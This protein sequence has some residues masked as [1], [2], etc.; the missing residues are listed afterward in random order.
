[1]QR[2]FLVHAKQDF[3]GV[4]VDDIT[5]GEEVEGVFMDDEDGNNSSKVSVK[6]REAVPLGHK[7]ALLDIKKGQKVIEY[8]EIIGAATQDIA[9]GS[10][11]HTHNIKSLRW[12][13]DSK[14]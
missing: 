2:K 9:K 8:G 13:A 6:S 10:H 5:N 11:V 14:N 12:S 4:A 1:M 7:I 3:V